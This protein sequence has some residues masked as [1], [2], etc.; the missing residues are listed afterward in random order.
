R[1]SITDDGDLMVRYFDKT[2]PITQNNVNIPIYLRFGLTRSVRPDPGRTLGGGLNTVTLAAASP[3]AWGEVDYR[4]GSAQYDPRHDIRPL[5][6]M[7]PEGQLGVAVAS[8]RVSVRD[9][10][11]F[12]VAGGRLVVFG[13]GDFVS[14]QRIGY[15][16]N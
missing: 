16:G 2:H 12:S 5:P 14:N 8:E 15:N 9:N 3:T 7:Q 10:L 13:T 4:A 6:G 1:N 11:P